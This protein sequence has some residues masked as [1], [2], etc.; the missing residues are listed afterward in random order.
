MQL[1]IT[2]LK[3][4][5]LKCE[6]CGETYLGSSCPRCAEKERAKRR[7]L[8]LAEKAFANYEPFVAE[9]L[10]HRGMCKR[11]LLADIKKIPKAVSEG[12]PQDA[13]K[14][15]MDGSPDRGFGISGP[16]GSGKTM[17]MAALVKAH[18]AKEGRSILP[19][20]G[21]LRCGWLLWRSWPTVADWLR[22]NAVKDAEA[23]QE[24]TTGL[25]AIPML[26]L[27]DLGAERMKGNYSDDYSRSQLDLII[28]SR[29]RNMLPTWYTT[30][31]DAAGLIE[32]YGS[33]LVSRLCG[34]NPMATITGTPDLRF[35]KGKP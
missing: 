21:V 31:T 8:A 33:R 17:A 29:Y 6:A 16:T 15:L 11:D 13:V 9:V 10:S 2:Q 25:C 27:D 12:L 23:V 19:E 20:Y 4:S 3:S 22:S 7:N 18:A 5:W 1:N 34:E 35:A 14:A 26:F 32:I 24:E 28:D 30:N